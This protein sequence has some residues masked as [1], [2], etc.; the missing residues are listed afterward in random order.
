MQGSNGC[1]FNV[2]GPKHLTLFEVNEAAEVIRQAVDPDANVIFGV[3]T[4]ESLRDEVRLDPHR[5]R[6]RR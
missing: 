1:I 3:G 5:H 2:V 4:D 6:L